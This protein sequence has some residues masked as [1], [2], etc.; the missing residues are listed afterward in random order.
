MAGDAL[1]AADV[2]RRK[3]CRLIS[4]SALAIAW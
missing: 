1:V 2:G 3:S 4:F